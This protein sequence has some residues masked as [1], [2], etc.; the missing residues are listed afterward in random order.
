MRS[1]KP[2]PLGHG[3][4]ALCATGD[5]PKAGGDGSPKGSFTKAPARI[6]TQKFARGNG[7][8]FGS[9]VSRESCRRAD[10]QS[11][12]VTVNKANRRRR[13]HITPSRFPNK[14][15]RISKASE[16]THWLT[17]RDGEA[18]ENNYLQGA[19]YGR[20]R[21]RVATTS[22]FMSSSHLFSMSALRSPL[23]LSR[24]AGPPSPAAGSE[25]VVLMVSGCRQRHGRPPR[26]RP[27]RNSR[28]LPL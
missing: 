15:F 10:K 8:V 5:T 17:N 25:G 13:N 21:L 2:Q 23:T 19:P 6:F 20:H 24:A 28:D 26:N 18:F 7:S 27:F 14:S 1:P 9:G 16:F 12:N 22:S 3:R 11:W 4:G